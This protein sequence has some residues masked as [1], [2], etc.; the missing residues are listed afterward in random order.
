MPRESLQSI[1]ELQRLARGEEDVGGDLLGHHADGGAGVARLLANP[2]DGFYLCADVA[3]SPNGAPAGALMVTWVHRDEAAPGE[4]DR[5]LR[6]V[7]EAR[8]EADVVVAYAHWGL[9]GYTCPGDDAIAAAR[10]LAVGSGTVVLLKGPVTVVVDGHHARVGMVVGPHHVGVR[11]VEIEARLI[12]EGPDLLSV[13][14]LRRSEPLLPA[15]FGPGGGWC[16]H[17]WLT[18]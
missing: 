18:S 5:L 4:R 8:Q 13:G 11:R 17:V 16:Q 14:R 7:R 15:P 2:R 1:Y 9:E 3:G 10:D 6:A 12:C